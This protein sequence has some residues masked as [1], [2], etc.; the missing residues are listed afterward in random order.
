MR[1][2]PP[3]NRHRIVVSALPTALIACGLVGL[4]VWL[5][6]D[7][8]TALAALVSAVSGCLALPRRK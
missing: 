8:A 7:R 2:P 6:A 5:P 1:R 4:V 3:L